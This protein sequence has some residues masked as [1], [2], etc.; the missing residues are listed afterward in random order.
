LIDIDQL[1]QFLDVAISKG[2]YQVDFTG[3]EIFVTSKIFEILDYL[4]TKPVITTLFTNLTLV[5]NKI[6]RE[7]K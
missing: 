7:I 3:G 5:N 6:L 4:E 1:K 2:V